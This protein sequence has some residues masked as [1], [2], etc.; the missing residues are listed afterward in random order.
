[1]AFDRLPFF[2]RLENSER[3]IVAG[4]GG[5][6]DVFCGLPLYFHLRGLGKTVTLAN[7]SFSNL[8]GVE[9]RELLPQ[10][11]EV[12]PD[13]GGSEHYFPERHLAQWFASRGEDVSIWC[14]HRTGVIPLA[15][16]Y[17]VLVEETKA[18]TVVLVD[19]GSDSL[20]RGDEYGLGTPQEDIASI[21]AVEQ[22]KYYVKEKLLL[23]VGFGVDAYHG[24]CH[25]QFL[26]AVA[27][28]I[29]TDGFLGSWSMM[30]A[31]EPFALYKEAAEFVFKAMPGNKSIVSSSVLAAISGEYGDVHPAPERT[32]GSTL[33][34][35]PLMAMMWAFDLPAVARRCL[36]LNQV[37][38][39]RTYREL[40]TAIE[41]FRANLP[42]TK[43]WQPIPV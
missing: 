8:Y 15:E 29:K 18:D 16:A 36:Y 25:A 22:I 31:E 4:A 12:G 19:G 27:E 43:D 24:V 34:I 2:D 1:M 5:G 33:W 13:A 14:F 39:T 11:I 7:L 21:A 20:M 9:G 30:A 32:E 40:N 10:M 42:E 38:R 41:T 6:Y 35:N 23:S 37:K 28:L 17:A 3:V 26:E